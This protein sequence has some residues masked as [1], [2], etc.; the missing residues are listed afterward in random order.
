MKNSVSYEGIKAI[1]VLPK[2]EGINVV[3][4]V[5]HSVE[6]IPAMALA[7]AEE[8]FDYIAPPFNQVKEAC[9]G[10]PTMYQWLIKSMLLNDYDCKDFACSFKRPCPTS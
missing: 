10:D 4:F 3:T 8:L 9:S 2:S 7:A 6:H 5:L 1:K